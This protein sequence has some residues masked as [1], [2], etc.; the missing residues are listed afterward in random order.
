MDANL[1]LQL[2]KLWPFL[3]VVLVTIVK[4]DFYFVQPSSSSVKQQC[5]KQQC[6]KQR[7]EHSE[8]NIQRYIR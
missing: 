6:K 4:E 7:Y 2:R 1:R 5:E 3:Q 8:I